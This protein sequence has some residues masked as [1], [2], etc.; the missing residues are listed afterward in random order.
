MRRT[1]AR[2]VQLRQVEQ[3]NPHVE[4]MGLAVCFLKT[5]YLGSAA[6]AGKDLRA[7]YP[8]YANFRAYMTDLNEEEKAAYAE[9]RVTDSNLTQGRR[10]RAD[11]GR[12]LRQ[13]VRFSFAGHDTPRRA[14]LHICHVLP[15]RASP[16][17]QDWVA[18]EIQRAVG[19]RPIDGW[20]YRADF[21]RLKRS[22]VVL[23]EIIR[24][25]TPV[26]VIKWTADKAQLLAVGGKTYML[27]ADCMVGRAT[28]PSRRTLASGGRTR[29][30]G[31]PPDLLSSTSAATARQRMSSASLC[32][33]LFGWSD[34]ARD[35]PG[36]KFSQVEFVAKLA[37]LFRSSWCVEP[38]TN[39]GESLD[40]ARRPRP[41]LIENDSRSVLLQ[42]MFHLE[43]APLVW[44]EQ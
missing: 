26:S 8:A 35:R 1:E 18:E 17:V 32:A 27:P 7:V 11:R 12:D 39:P 9:S 4:I 24:L 44:K 5:P 30:N 41:D 19:D 3:L 34:G 23:Y 28:A 37:L 10:R 33:A 2:G 16:D 21:P 36:R 40:A 22:L 6:A 25:Y 13:Y 38:V 29:W 15:G 14:Q 42:Q 31:A 20:G 43:R